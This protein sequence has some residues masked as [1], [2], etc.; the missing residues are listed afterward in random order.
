[1]WQKLQSLLN[2]VLSTELVELPIA[3]LVKQWSHLMLYL[4]DDN[5]MSSTVFLPQPITKGPVACL[6]TNPCTVAWWS[7]I[8]GSEL[9]GWAFL[10]IWDTSSKKLSLMLPINTAPA[11]LSAKYSLSSAFSFPGSLPNSHI[12]PVWIA[13]VDH[14]LVIWCLLVVLGS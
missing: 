3:R 11:I 10:A 4:L 13:E 1:M 9:W 6:S 14:G 2:S 7:H 12:A 5:C 8:S